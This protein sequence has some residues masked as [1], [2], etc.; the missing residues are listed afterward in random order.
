M[1]CWITIKVI[2]E[3]FE[4][5]PAMRKAAEALG[6]K[7]EESGSN[8][9]IGGSIKVTKRG[10]TYNMSTTE[11]SLLKSLMD[12]YAAAKIAREARRKNLNVKKQKASDGTITLKIYEN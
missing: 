4:D 3:Q 5:L 2:Q 6:L 8:M 9:W 12:E 7:I 10:N 1:P 11:D